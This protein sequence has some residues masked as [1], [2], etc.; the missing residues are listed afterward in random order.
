MSYFYQS[1]E[2]MSDFFFFRNE[3]LVYVEKFNHV[4]LVERGI[5]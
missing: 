3:R 1:G 4:V 5:N 2:N